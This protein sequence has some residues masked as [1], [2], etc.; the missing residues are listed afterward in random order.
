[1]GVGVDGLLGWADALIHLLRADDILPDMGR[2]A[3]RIVEANYSTH[4]VAP[5]VA[6]ALKGVAR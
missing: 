6:D 2:T 5:M 4:V 1:M 3:R